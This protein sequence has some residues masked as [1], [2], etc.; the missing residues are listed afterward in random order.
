M[1]VIPTRPPDNAPRLAPKR[2]FGSYKKIYRIFC[3]NGS[4]AIPST[5][6]RFSEMLPAFDDRGGN[7]PL[8]LKKRGDFKN[9]KGDLILDGNISRDYQTLVHITT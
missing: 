5:G 8:G 6:M 1:P 4:G 2:L 3:Y 9:K 7:S